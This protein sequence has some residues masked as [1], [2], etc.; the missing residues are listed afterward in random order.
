[1]QICITSTYEPACPTCMP[2]RISSQVAP[3]A[4]HKA[5]I[6]DAVSGNIVLNDDNPALLP[7]NHLLLA[8]EIATDEVTGLPWLRHE[9][10]WTPFVIDG[11]S[12]RIARASDC[13]PIHQNYTP[14]FPTYLT[15][16]AYPRRYCSQRRGL[17]IACTTN[18]EYSSIIR[19]TETSSFGAAR[20]IW[21]MPSVTLIPLRSLL[22]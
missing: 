13:A 9:R 22:P 3:E 20:L 17:P 19:A 2:L 4:K 12:V 18:G 6:F 10:G 7:S 11:V 14:G 8:H 15:P 21:R 5:Y 16:H 1:M